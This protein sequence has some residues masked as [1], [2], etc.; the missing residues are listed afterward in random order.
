MGK[1]ML[2]PEVNGNSCNR[3]RDD[4]I[5]V[6]DEFRDMV[7]KGG[8]REFI[9]TGVSSEDGNLIL[10]SYCGSLSEGVGILELGKY[11]LIQRQMSDEQGCQ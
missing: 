9:I 2:M 11:S 1:S 8:V 5:A 4:K 3:G 7:E 6:I 10:A